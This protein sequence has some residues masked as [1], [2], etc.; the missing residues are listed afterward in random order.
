MKKSLLSTLALAFAVSALPL[1]A[2]TSAQDRYFAA[3]QGGI[4]M[5]QNHYTGQSSSN[6]QFTYNIVTDGAQRLTNIEARHDA[7]GNVVYD[8]SY[9]LGSGGHALF[10][11]IPAHSLVGHQIGQLG[12]GR[13]LTK[14]TSYLVADGTRLYTALFSKASGPQFFYMGLDSDEYGD[15]VAEL[16]AAPLSLSTVAVEAYHDADGELRFDAAFSEQQGGGHIWWNM[17]E[18]L[19]LSKNDEQESAGRRLVL[20]ETYRT[21][22]GSRRYLARWSSVWQSPFPPTP[23]ALFLGQDEGTFLTTV[24]SE[25]ALGRVLIC[26]AVLEDVTPADWNNYDSGLAGTNGVPT[27]TLDAN[28]FLGANVVIEMGSSAPSSTLCGLF[29][30]ISQAALPFKGGELLLIPAI[31][32]ILLPL[33]TSGLDLPVTLPADPIFDGVELFLQTAMQ[34]NGAPVGVS[35]SRGLKMTMGAHD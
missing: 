4:L 27:L 31:D 8:T 19:F 12:L 7:S 32:P 13:H 26:L 25:Q 17:T 21:N 28:P 9:N 18:S 1:A 5:N 6:V 15:L 11:D 3:F 24:Q 23:P 20:M 33:T 34:D 35:L 16:I 14:L 2:D 10:M 22:T 30:G 29:L